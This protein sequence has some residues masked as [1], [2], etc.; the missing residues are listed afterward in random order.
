MTISNKNGVTKLK[1]KFIEQKNSGEC[2][3]QSVY[4]I[5]HGVLWEPAFVDGNQAVRINAGHPYYHKV[6]IPNKK[7]GVTV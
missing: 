1:I 7:S 5:Q 4:S 2:H 3:V 6:Y